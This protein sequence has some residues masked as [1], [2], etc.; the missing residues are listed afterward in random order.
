M[1]EMEPVMVEL[2]KIAYDAYCDC[3]GGISLISGARLPLWNEL[4][5]EIKAAWHA[6]AEAV[7]KCYAADRTDL[8]D[9]EGK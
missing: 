8:G 3:T 4:Q 2:G 1:I 5:E 6:S 9:D 7:G